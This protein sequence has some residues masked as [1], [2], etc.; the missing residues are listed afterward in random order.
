MKKSNTLGTI[1]HTEHCGTAVVCR[2]KN[3][4]KVE[5]FFVDTGYTLVTTNK[6][7]KSE[8]VL[9]KDPLARKVHSVG[10]CGV[11]RHRPTVNDKHPTS[12]R[13]WVYMIGRCYYRKW[14]SYNLVTVCPEWH[15]YQVFAK[16]FDENYPTDGLHYDLDKDILKPGNKVYGPKFCTFVTHA[17]NN[18]AIDRK[19]P[20]KSNHTPLTPEELAEKIRL[21]CAASEWTR[22]AR[23][24]R[25]PEFTL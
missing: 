1:V 10:F 20:R 25:A 12:Y 13:R 18:A 8:R 23:L 3:H 9:L 5:V 6:A 7:I 22:T 15:D 4:L 17:E 16:W 11:G 14:P 24:R 21:A 2:Y 19:T